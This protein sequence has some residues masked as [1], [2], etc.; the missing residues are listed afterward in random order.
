MQVGASVGF[1][2]L[3]R[4]QRDSVG[5]Y[6]GSG[7]IDSDILVRCSPVDPEPGGPAHPNVAGSPLGKTGS[8]L[9]EFQI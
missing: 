8:G 3:G 6:A 4:P 5:K 9:G 7:N 1:A 2:G